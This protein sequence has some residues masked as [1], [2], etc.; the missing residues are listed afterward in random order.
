MFSG[1]NRRLGVKSTK[2]FRSVVVIEDVSVRVEIGGLW[3]A[4]IV[5]V[6]VR[7]GLGGF[8]VWLLLLVFSLADGHGHGHA[9]EK[10]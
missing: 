3:D 6:G 4:G 10:V 8:W 9:Q 1:W 7:S 2:R 5:G